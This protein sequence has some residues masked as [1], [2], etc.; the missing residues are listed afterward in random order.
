MRWRYLDCTAHIISDK[1]TKN[2]A[3]R[4]N[5]KVIFVTSQAEMSLHLR[6]KKTLSHNF[7]VTDH[8]P[9]RKIGIYLYQ[10]IIFIR[11]SQGKTR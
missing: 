6:G 3:Y 4:R 8:L 1:E 11:K 2:I 9:F 7:C 5:N 10:H